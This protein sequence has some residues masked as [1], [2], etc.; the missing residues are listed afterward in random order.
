M[1]YVYIAVNKDKGLIKVGSTNNIEDR[2]VRLDTP[3]RD[4]GLV[5]MKH[6]AIP[7]DSRAYSWAIE[8]LLRND[9]NRYAVVHTTFDTFK[10][11]TAEFRPL[12]Y[13]NHFERKVKN[14]I[15]KI[16]KGSL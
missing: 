7:S 6:M 16:G 4:R 2:Q 11:N 15:K 9:L 10:Y 13:V 14:A 3:P 1:K 5:I 12:S 8:S